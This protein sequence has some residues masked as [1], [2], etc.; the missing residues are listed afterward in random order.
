MV[1]PD[2]FLR[3]SFCISLELYVIVVLILKLNIIIMK[4]TELILILNDIRH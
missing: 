3:I 2:L 4:N 1:V